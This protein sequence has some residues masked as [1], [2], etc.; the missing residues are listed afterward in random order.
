MLRCGRWMVVVILACFVVACQSSAEDK[1]TEDRFQQELTYL[2]G[3]NPVSVGH[4]ALISGYQELI[5]KYPTDPRI[6]EAMFWIAVELESSHGNSGQKPDHLAATQWY[7][8]AVDASQ[9]GTAIWIKSR[10]HLAVRLPYVSEGKKKNLPESR[11]LLQEIADS[12]QDSSLILAEL[13]NAWISQCKLE[14]DLDGVQQ[15]VNNLLN[16]YEAPERIPKDPHHK[17]IVDGYIAGAARVMAETW[18]IAKLP[19][20]ERARRIEQI[21]TDH[22][23]LPGVAQTADRLLKQMKQTVSVEPELVPLTSTNRGTPW[24]IIVSVHFLI[25]LA[26]AVILIRRRNCD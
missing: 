23:N 15:H 25:L 12:Q 22:S 13:E 3:Q 17:R 1:E 4:E 7:G 20:A 21:K 16:W 6:A 5:A 14:E 9:P 10:F 18:A 2:R 8:K 24:L 26:F 19:T 11:R